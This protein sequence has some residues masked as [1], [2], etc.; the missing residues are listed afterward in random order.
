MTLLH[1][2]AAYDPEALFYFGAATGFLSMF[3]LA[4]A[5][6]IKGGDDR[7][8]PRVWALS[9]AGT[10]VS[11]AMIGWSVSRMAGEM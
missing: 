5:R 8:L 2:L 4:L 3:G 6:D 9:L 11:A 7:G 1:R 10:T